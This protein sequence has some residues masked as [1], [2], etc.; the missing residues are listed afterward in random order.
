MTVE[1]KKPKPVK[2]KE[3]EW[4]NPMDPTQP[5]DERD[6]ERMIRLFKEAKRQ[7]DNLTEDDEED[8]TKEQQ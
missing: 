1:D 2:E 3:K 7:H 4:E 5:S 8:K 6:R